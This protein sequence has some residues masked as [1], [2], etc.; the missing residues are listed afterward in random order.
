MKRN[1]WLPEA[2]SI[3]YQEQGKSPW[4]F[5]QGWSSLWVQVGSSGGGGTRELGAATLSPLGSATF[6]PASG[7]RHCLGS[8]QGFTPLGGAQAG[9]KPGWC[10]CGSC[11]SGSAC[12]QHCWRQKAKIQEDHLKSSEPTRI[13]RFYSF[14]HMGISAPLK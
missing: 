13:F 3:S 14:V 12:S 10:L 1:S 11:W 2:F 8:E 6:L 5:W 7:P 4:C 9:P